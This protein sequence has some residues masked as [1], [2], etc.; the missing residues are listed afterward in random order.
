MKAII[1]WN[2][3]WLSQVAAPGNTVLSAAN[4]PATAGAPTCDRMLKMKAKTT[5]VSQSGMNVSNPV[6]R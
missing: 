5:Q 4:R 3:N 2:H 1:D 6:I